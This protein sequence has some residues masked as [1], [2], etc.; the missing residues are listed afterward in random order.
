[1]AY[2]PVSQQVALGLRSFQIYAVG[3]APGVEGG[4]RLY[5]PVTKLII[6]RRSFKFKVIGPNPTIQTHFQFLAEPLES[7]S[8]RLPGRMTLMLLLIWN[9]MILLISP[10]LWCLRMCSPVLFQVR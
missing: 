5:N 6:I 3:V 10:N 1:M 8:S 4:A 9:F 2:V 7:A